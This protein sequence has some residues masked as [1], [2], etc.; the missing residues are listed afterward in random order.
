MSE[1]KRINKYLSEMGVCSRREADR[2]IEEGR[3][4]VAGNK[5]LPGQKLTGDEEVC[6]D[7]KVIGS[8][9]DAKKVKKVILAVNKPVGV[10]CTSSDKDRATTITE[11]M[12]EYPERLFPVGRLDKDSD[13]LILMTN[14]G[15]LANEIAKARNYHEKEYIVKVNKPITQAFLKKMGG[16][17]Y[18]KELNASTRPCEI[19]AISDNEFRIVL[20]QGL[21][22]QIRRMCEECDYRVL[23]LTRVRIMNVRLGRLKPG[24]WK[25][26]DFPLDI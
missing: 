14:D 5:A 17:M 13:G 8:L 2:M 16:G 3:V 10:V 20:T 18:L 6:V 25:R 12:Q 11:M 19:E 15:D 22:R 24:T 7:G 4:T 9:H 23:K 21:N 1:E 26:I